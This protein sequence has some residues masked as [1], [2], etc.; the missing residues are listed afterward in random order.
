MTSLHRSLCEA[1]ARRPDRPAL[2]Q[3]RRRLSYG[4]LLSASTGLADRLRADGLS[5]GDSAAVQMPNCIES[6]VALSALSG[7]GA[8]AMLLDPGYKAEEAAKYCRQG[9]IR[10]VLIPEGVA[11]GGPGARLA[12]HRVPPAESLPAAAEHA[13]RDPPDETRPAFMLLSSGTTGTP[14]VVPKTVPQAAAAVRI[15]LDTLPYRE[16]DRVLAVLPFFHSFGLVNVLLATM[17]AGATLYVQPFS[18]RHTA[19]LIASERITVLP[20]TPFMFRLLGETQFR[21]VPDLSSVRLAVSAGSALAQAVGRRFEEAFGVGL[22]QSYGTTEAGPIT[23]A[24]PQER[25][26]QTGWVGRPYEDVAVQVWD[27]AGTAMSPGQEGEVAVRSAA[28]AAG[29][30]NNPDAT[31]ETFRKGWVLTGDIASSDADG[32]LFVLGRRKPM[33]NVAGKKVAPAEVEARLLSH[34][35]VADAVVTGTR[36]KGTS[37]TVKAL[38][39]ATGRVSAVQLQEFCAAGLA[40][41]KVPRLIEFVDNLSAGPMD[42]A[43]A[44]ASQT[45]GE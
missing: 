29:Y 41:F 15:F 13:L 14:K 33:I 45:P 22:H 42:K 11:A 38:V 44:R 5:E 2:V 25:V 37:E 26:E 17:A 12:W 20:G 39:V 36:G 34:P 10:H 40:D 9:G 16:G 43:P 23:V 21:A 7:L 32:N 6:V 30:L 8:C 35:A 27:A 1:A 31:A 4:R 24:R 28:N 3:G 19:N 18:P